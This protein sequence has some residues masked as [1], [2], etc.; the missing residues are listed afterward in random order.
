M[1]VDRLDYTMPPASNVTD[2]TIVVDTVKQKRV[3]IVGV[4]DETADDVVISYDFNKNPITV[5][6]RNEEFGASADETV[7]DAVYVES[8]DIEDIDD[9]DRKERVRAI[10][11]EY[12]KSFAFPESRLLPPSFTDL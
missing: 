3:V 2:G 7:C 1:S 11:S 9:M 6:D 12:A 8:L 4:R 10:D 5:Y